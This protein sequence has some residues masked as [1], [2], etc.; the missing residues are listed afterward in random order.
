MT[1]F[2]GAGAMKPFAPAD[3]RATTKAVNAV[4]R[5]IVTMKLCTVKYGVSGAFRLLY[6]VGLI[7]LLLVV[8]LQKKPAEGRLLGVEWPGL[9][10]EIRNQSPTSE[11]V[12]PTRRQSIGADVRPLLSKIKN[13]ESRTHFA[14][15]RISTL[16]TLGAPTEKRVSKCR[17]YVDCVPHIYLHYMS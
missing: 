7:D 17:P 6:F 13:Q 2:D 4:D 10:E 16:Y 8:W 3:K 9:K 12:S 14:T 5:T 1:T 15:I 11:R